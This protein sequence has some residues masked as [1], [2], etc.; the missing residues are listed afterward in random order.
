MTTE[1][2]K[3]FFFFFWS[4]TNV[5]TTELDSFGQI[6]ESNPSIKLVDLPAYLSCQDEKVQVTCLIMRRICYNIED[7]DAFDS[8]KLL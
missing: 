1:P 2:V 8:R 6:Q 4:S 3:F 7:R 5:Q